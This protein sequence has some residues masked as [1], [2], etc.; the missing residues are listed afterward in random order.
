MVTR[1]PYKD[2][3]GKVSREAGIPHKL[4]MKKRRK[5]GEIVKRR[6][7]E[8]SSLK[9]EVMQKVLEPVVQERM[10]QGQRVKRKGPVWSI[11]DYERSDKE[12]QIKRKDGFLSCWRQTLRK[13]GFTGRILCRNGFRV[14][15]R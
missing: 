6:R 9:L 8:G 13:R 3:L 10:S 2:L 14:W 7:I 11:G 15:R 12:N 1:R 4:K 5:A